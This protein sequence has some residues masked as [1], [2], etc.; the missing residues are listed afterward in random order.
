MPRKKAHNDRN[1]TMS[2]RVSETDIARLKR[3]CHRDELRPALFAY[4]ALMAG[5]E[6][7]TKK[8]ETHGYQCMAP[9]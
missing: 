7:L 5:V 4:E 8:Q 9:L 1:I 2:I 3:V 6:K